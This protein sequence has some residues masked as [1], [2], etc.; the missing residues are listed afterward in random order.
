M[1]D[2]DRPARAE[3]RQRRG[4]PSGR[5]RGDLRRDPQRGARRGT[6]PA[7]GR[8]AAR[9]APGPAGRGRAPARPPGQGAAAR[10]PRR[11]G[12]SVGSP[13]RS[14]SG[15]GDAPWLLDTSV[16]IDLTDP[17]VLAALPET[18]AISVVTIAELAA[19]PLVTDDDAE[20]ARRQRHLQEVEALFDPIPVDAAAARAFGEIVSAVRRSGRQPRR[21]QFDLLIAAVARANRLA[22]ATRN[23]VD[24]AGL[25]DLVEVHAV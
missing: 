7:P 1:G 14:A 20:R 5:G 24:L 15:A 13:L 12:G 10:R 11:R 19:G 21:R 9:R 4:H 6:A 16:V 25:E 22:V 3:E 23:P 8:E 17:A 18:T 2:R